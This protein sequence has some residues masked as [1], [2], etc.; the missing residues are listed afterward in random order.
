MICAAS[1]KKTTVVKSTSTKKRSK[2]N[3]GRP[4]RLTSSAGIPRAGT[5][6][7]SKRIEIQQHLV[8][9]LFTVGGQAPRNLSSRTKF[10]SSGQASTRAASSREDGLSENHIPTNIGIVIGLPPA[11]RRTLSMS[12]STTFETQSKMPTSRTQR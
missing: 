10:S 9:R 2:A 5:G 12:S 3:G 7:H 11:K 8:A 4:E 1:L 6:K